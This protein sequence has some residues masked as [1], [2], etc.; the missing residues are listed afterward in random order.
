MKFSGH[1]IQQVGLGL[2]CLLSTV[3]GQVVP[4]Q[5]VRL[6]QPAKG[7]EVTLFASEPMLASPTN[8]D[9]DDRG[10]VWVCE[11]VNYR[12]NQNLRPKGDRILILDDTDGDGKADQTSVFYQGTDVNSAMGIAVLGNKV[13]VTCSPNIIVFTDND[14][15]DRAD[16]KQYMFTETGRGQSDHAAHSFVFGPDGRLYWNFGNTGKQV[17][18]PRGFVVKDPNGLPITD[19]GQPFHGGMVFRCEPD[20][21]KLEV[22]G[23]N[24]R[25]NYEVAVDSFGTVWQSDNDDDGNEA[26]RI[27][28]VMEYG[29]FGYRDEVDGSGWQDWRLGQ[30]DDIPRRHWHQNDPGV[31]PNVLVTGAGSPAGMTVYEGALLPQVYR[32]QLIHCEAG[33]RAIR[34]YAMTKKGA[35]YTG[36]T[37]E[38]VNG[39]A[40][41]WFRPIDV[42]VAPD[43][44]LFVS[45]WYDPVVGGNGMKDTTRGRI[46]RIAPKGAPYKRYIYDFTD[47]AASVE[48]MKSPNIA[49]RFQAWAALR[50]AGDESAIGNLLLDPNPRFRARGLWLLSSFPGKAREAIGLAN[51][52]L[53]EDIRALSPRIARAR[54]MKVLPVVRRLAGDKSAIVR[55][56]CAIALRHETGA[57][58]A[59]TWAKLAV[60]HDG[61]D[62]WYLEAL[63]IGAAKQWDLC[64]AAWF[65]KTNQV[66]DHLA[67]RD[68]VWRSRSRFTPGLLAELVL[69]SGSKSDPYARYIRAF[70][71]QPDATAR[72]DGLLK[73]FDSTNLEFTFA[74]ATDL[75]YEDL[76]TDALRIGRIRS[77]I[78]EFRGKPEL[79][80][81]VD[82][83]DI[84][85]ADE[86]LLEFALSRPDQPEALR[87]TQLLMED[88][89]A[90]KQTIRG[91]VQEAMGFIRLMGRCSD[92][93]ANAIL[94]DVLK[95]SGHSNSIRGA[96]AEALTLNRAGASK[97]LELAK[98][99]GLPKVLDQPMKVQLAQVPWDGVRREAREV[100]D[101]KVSAASGQ[102][103]PA[104]GELVARSG[105][106]ARGREVFL[107]GG[108]AT[109]HQI[110][111]QYVN[112][113]P[114]L[115]QVGQKLG[116]EALF[117]AILN[118][119]NAISNGF[120]G[121]RIQLRNGDE[122][123][124]FLTSEGTQF[125][126][127]RMA[128]GVDRRISVDDIASRGRLKNSLMPTELAEAFTAD[129]L[130]D[131]V[132]FL[133]SMR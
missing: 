41:P 75:T 101:I 68:I 71:F 132:A 59:T 79:V 45:D 118:P 11:V 16:T 27:N 30:S 85:T 78:R 70:Q 56:E 84:R 77:L 116:K 20:G 92:G 23:H 90:V 106:S 24:F 53:D 83:L 109:C 76:A 42:A 14:G 133:A 66:W 38:L 48:A 69:S 35:G 6:L 73:V 37:T 36:K 120:E 81:L 61:E 130:V 67:G 29:N 114:D 113:G 34:A 9:V 82:A 47:P 128:G 129:E 89:S 117:D 40:D 52:D 18:D 96:V 102:K 97:L 74:A 54:G 112:F 60:A 10:R 28:Y 44:S 100:F 93:R 3:V 17:A 108:C 124:G 21:T 4:E 15:D 72:R 103:L 99:G 88:S 86:E 94:L 65:E 125:L 110:N 49:V 111:G 105:N 12:K 8:I 46:Y 126:T 43:G 127:L 33:S 5:A 26:V 55:R 50:A 39:E 107:T 58:A 57:E 19:K 122:Y 25:N 123:I 115:S 32:N 104:V 131:V 80:R 95:D 2:V 121:H 31:V 87:A 119:N 91:G 63:G 13:I 62:R 22:L 98:Q 7:L 64:F 1:A 51:F